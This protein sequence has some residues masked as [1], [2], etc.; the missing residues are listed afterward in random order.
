MGQKINST[1]FRLGYKQNKWDSK[2]QENKFIKFS[3]Y[4]LEESFI[5]KFLM[6]IFS[7]H[8]IKV[9]DIKLNRTEQLLFLKVVLHFPITLRKVIRNVLKQKQIILK[10][11]KYFIAKTTNVSQ[12]TR[13]L[14]VLSYLKKKHSIENNVFKVYFSDKIIYVLKNFMSNRVDICLTL[15]ATKSPRPNVFNLKFAGK[16]KKKLLQLRKFSKASFFKDSLNSF[17]TTLFFAASSKLLADVLAF[18][19]KYL[20]RHNYFFNFLKRCITIL[21]SFPEGFVEGIKINVTG[22]LNG[23]PRSSSKIIQL[24]KISLQSIES[25]IH[26]NSVSAFSNLGVFGIKVWICEKSKYIA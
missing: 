26:Y 11:K 19:I 25:K 17:I 15:F 9:L 3:D 2:H 16:L 22:R 24:G 6:T 5:K 20:K 8:S 21:L 7:K 1:L 12:K 23:K 4:M 18:H 10:P 13:R 14:W